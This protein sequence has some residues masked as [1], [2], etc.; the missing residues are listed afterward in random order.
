MFAYF[1]SGFSPSVCHRVRP[2][3]GTGQSAEPE[4][5]VCQCGSCLRIT[6]LIVNN[7]IDFLHFRVCTFDFC[8]RPGN[9][10]SFSSQISSCELFFCA[11]TPNES[12]KN[13]V[14]FW[15]GGALLRHFVQ[16]TVRRPGG[17]AAIGRQ[18]GEGGTNVTVGAL[19]LVAIW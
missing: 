7:Y 8:W 9:G 18:R 3:S 11:V 6:L 4:R 15:V 1:Y 13:C 12:V 10:K 2:V 17:H 14:F 16:R 5:S 19:R